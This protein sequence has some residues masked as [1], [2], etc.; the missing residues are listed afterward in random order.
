VSG[1]AGVQRG[2]GPVRVGTQHARAGQRDRTHTRRRV[3][4][5]GETSV[6]CA[7]A[8]DCTVFC[9]EEA[10]EDSGGVSGSLTCHHY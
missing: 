5:E 3:R 7:G 9:G 2:L 10:G 4:R 1:A 8:T 6:E